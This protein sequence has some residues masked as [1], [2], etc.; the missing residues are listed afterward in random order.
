[1]AFRLEGLVV[2]AGLGLAVGLALLLA[3]LLGPM[4]SSAD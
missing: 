3:S 1:M 2:I 4:V